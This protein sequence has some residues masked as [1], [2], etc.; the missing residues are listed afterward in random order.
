MQIVFS[1]FS[2]AASKY[3]GIWV[4]DRVYIVA[5][6]GAFTVGICGNI[7]SRFYHKTAFTCMVIGILFLVPVSATIGSPKV[8][9]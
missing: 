2:F 9:H 3:A 5:G 6:I 8:Y 7:Y 1:C 4:T